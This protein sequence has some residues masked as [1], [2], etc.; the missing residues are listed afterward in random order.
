M[1]GCDWT[2]TLRVRVVA[3]A[4]V[5]LSISS[6]L[7][8]GFFQLDTWPPLGGSITQVFSLSIYWFCSKIIFFTFTNN[9]SPNSDSSQIATVLTIRTAAKATAGPS[10]TTVS[11]TTTTASKI[12]TKKLSSS[13]ITSGSIGNL[14][15]FSKQERMRRIHWADKT[16]GKVCNGNR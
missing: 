10:T 8:L 4:V 7:S 6:L 5:R 11:K 16:L 15:R 3:V 13:M 1:G 14:L 2:E 12:T 9:G